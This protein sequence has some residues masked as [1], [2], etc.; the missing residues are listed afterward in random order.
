MKIHDTALPSVKRITLTTHRDGRGFFREI[1]HAEALAAEGLRV[2]LVQWNHSRSLP[3]VIRGIHF[4]HAPMQGKLVSVAHGAVLDVAVDLRPHSPNF[5]KHVAVELSAENSEMLW[6]PAGFGHGFCVLGDAPADV[7]Y[8]M[9]A[10][11]NAAGESG[12]AYNDPQLAIDWPVANPI[13]SVR[14]AA[15]PSIAAAMDDL[16]GWFGAMK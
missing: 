10:H 9:S 3:G 7:V 15:Q 14:D 8:G 2:P 6:I 1:Y 16:T 5:T 4:Q 12:V 11:Y 13:V